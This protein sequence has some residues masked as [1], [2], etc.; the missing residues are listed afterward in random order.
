MLEYMYNSLDEFDIKN[1]S[2]IHIEPEEG[3]VLKPDGVKEKLY[4]DCISKTEQ[5]LRECQVGT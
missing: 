4:E 3:D 2:R 1:S 5:Y